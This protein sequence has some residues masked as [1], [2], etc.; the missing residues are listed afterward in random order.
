MEP[1]SSKESLDS[2]EGTCVKNTRTGEE[3]RYDF[4]S[5]LV[6]GIPHPPFIKEKCVHALQKQLSFRAGDLFVCTYS[7]CGT[8]LMEQV[9]LLLQNNGDASKMNPLHKNTYDR[10]T[11]VGK[12]W[13]EMA[14]VPHSDTGDANGNGMDNTANADNKK[15]CMGENKAR[16]SVNEFDSISN[17]V[18]KTHAPT[19]LFLGKDD[20]IGENGFRLAKGIKV[21]YVTRNPFDACVSCYYHPKPGVSPES[22]GCSFAAFAKLWLTKRIEFGGWSNHIA[23]WRRAYHENLEHAKQTQSSPQILWISYEELVKS[24]KA[25]VAKVA[26]FMDIDASSDLVDAVV[27]GC[28][29]EKM[30]ESARKTMENGTGGNISHL[31]KGKIGDWRNHF[32]SQLKEEFEEKLKKNLPDALDVVYDIGDGETW[33]LGSSSVGNN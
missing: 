27:E 17:R 18:M 22:N 32:T 23:G 9:V 5:S 14:V 20:T 26:N 2:D 7:K 21:I 16:M 28:K 30:K 33:S 3:Y 4:A 12:I 13:P 11:G 29:F 24:P 10:N 31:R 25:S 1:V 8:S 6:D 15:A 19:S